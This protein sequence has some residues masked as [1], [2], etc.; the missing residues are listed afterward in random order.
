MTHQ[1]SSWIVQL[2]RSMGDTSKD[3]HGHSDSHSGGGELEMVCVSAP[4]G[5]DRQDMV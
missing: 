2:N 5:V 4:G 1:C 3:V